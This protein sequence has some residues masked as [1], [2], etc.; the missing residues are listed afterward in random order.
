MALESQT[1]EGGA[2]GSQEIMDAAPPLRYP[3]SVASGCDR[4]GIGVP[5]TKPNVIA[6][7]LNAGTELSA[8]AK[9]SM[10]KLSRF[11]STDVNRTKTRSSNSFH[12]F[13]KRLP[14]PSARNFLKPIPS[15]ITSMSDPIRIVNNLIAAMLLASVLAVHPTWSLAQSPT[16]E[17]LRE[18]AQRAITI[19]ERSS[20]EYLKQRECFSCHHQSMSIATLID[21]QSRGLQ[22]DQEN[23]RRQ[24]ERS[25]EH[26]KRGQ[27]DYQQGQGQGGG[28]D[29][30]V[31]H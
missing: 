14:E 23:L 16:S 28:V 19:I 6:L 3:R 30:A 4:A 8:V 27:A 13:R 18:S 24:V 2:L 20:A 1:F 29:T 25:L 31:M 10:Q 15:K 7:L 9:S 26:L 11:V 17:Q 22:V 21:A 12:S 5:P